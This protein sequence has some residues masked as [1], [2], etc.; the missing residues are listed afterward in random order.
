MRSS[1]IYGFQFSE[2][3]IGE[4]IDE[5][6]ILVSQPCA[7]NIPQTDAGLQEARKRANLASLATS[8]LCDEDT[9][10]SIIEVASGSDPEPSVC[11]SDSDSDFAPCKKKSTGLENS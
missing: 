4:H 7:P 5:G 8:D 9:D 10:G 1:K 6:L 2:A 11:K 3:L